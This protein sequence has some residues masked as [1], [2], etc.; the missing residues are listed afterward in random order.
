MSNIEESYKEEDARLVAIKAAA[1]EEYLAA[2][3]AAAAEEE[4]R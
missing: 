4:S 3:Q 1:K 2:M